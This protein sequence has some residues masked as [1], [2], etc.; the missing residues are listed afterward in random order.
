MKNNEAITQ[1][2]IDDWKKQF[3]ELS[4]TT[5]GDQV[6]IWH[7][8]SRNDYKNVMTTEY[9]DDNSKVFNRQDDIV[10]NCVIYPENIEE[11]IEKKGGVATTLAD[12]I[13]E[14]AGFGATKTEKL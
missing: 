4:K 6:Y 7:G 12:E 11:I 1:E 3:G 2:M 8:L 9:E 14:D 5:I 10:C 13:L